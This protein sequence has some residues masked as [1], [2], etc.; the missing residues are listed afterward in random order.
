MHFSR[1]S[2]FHQFSK[3]NLKGL[4][5]AG[6]DQW[7]S[8]W[9]G[10]GGMNLTTQHPHRWTFLKRGEKHLQPGCFWEQG[11]QGWWKRSK[12]Y[13]TLLQRFLWGFNDLSGNAL[14][15]QCFTSHIKGKQ[16]NVLWCLSDQYISSS[17]LQKISL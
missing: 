3:V 1:E 10:G 6:G 2:I 8:V 12:R 15:L 7:V 17:Y 9:Q 16:K 13:V 4:T 14:L 11:T 5:L